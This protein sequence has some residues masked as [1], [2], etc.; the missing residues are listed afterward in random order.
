MKLSL[1]EQ[2]FISCI[3]LEH[4]PQSDSSFDPCR[5]DDS[6]D[7]A[8]APKGG[9]AWARGRPPERVGRSKDA[10]TTSHR[11]RG[12]MKITTSLLAGA[13]LLV[14]IAVA[15]APCPQIRRHPRRVGQ[16]R[17]AHRVPAGLA[18]GAAGAEGRRHSVQRARALA[19]PRFSHAYLWGLIAKVFLCLIR[20][21]LHTGDA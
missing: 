12:P 6:D 9:R 14:G 3:G 17:R 11:W 5:S 8:L 20:Q 10:Y 7:A 19:R 15:T 1:G 4:E 18:R 21:S 13:A 2:V 16:V